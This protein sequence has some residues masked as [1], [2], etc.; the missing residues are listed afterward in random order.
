M[1]GRSPRNLGYMRAFA[2]A[3]PDEG[4]VQQGVAQL[5]W[6]HVVRLIEAVK[7]P[8]QRLW[9][10]S[11]ATEQVWNRNVLVHQIESGLYAR[12]GRAL[13]NFARTLPAPQSDLAQQIIKDPYSL[14]FLSVAHEISERELERGLLEHLRA[15][16]LELGNGLAFVGSQYHLEVA[17]Q[18]YYLDLL[19]YHLRLRC[20]VVIELMVEE[21]KPEFAG[22]MTSI[23]PP[24][25][26]CCAMKVTRR[27]L[28][29]SSARAGTRSL[30]STPSGTRQSRWGLPNIG[31]RT[32]CRSGSKRIFRG[33][34]N[35]TVSF[36]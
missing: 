17:G 36:L 35:S 27:V 21:F 10:A 3:F 34:P 32:S 12:Q 1:S 33:E 5:P 11:Q 26:T 22:K 24:W 19:F 15:L 18:D 28:A 25:M 13:T 4:I 2:E 16:I 7:S 14:E 8:D 6:G 29:S 30:A 20:F 9:Y 23:C 31:S